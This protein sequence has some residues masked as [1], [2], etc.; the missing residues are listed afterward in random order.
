M[1]LRRVNGLKAHGIAT[2]TGFSETAQR[3]FDADL[4][5]VILALE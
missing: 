4:V 5:H 2:V 3:R 1:I